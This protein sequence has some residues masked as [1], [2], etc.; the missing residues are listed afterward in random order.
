[1]AQQVFAPPIQRALR[2]EVYDAIRR[3]VVTNV[4][5]PGER[6]NEAEIARQ[7]QI[8]RAPIREALRQLEQEGLLV[9]RPRRGTFVVSLSRTDV[10]EV[11]TL[12]ADLECRAIRRAMEHLTPALCRTLEALIEEME[13][14]GRAS[15]VTR[16][17]EAD[18]AF[19]RAIVDAAGWHRLRRIWEG[20]HPQTLTTYTLTTLTD[21]P[22]SCHADRHRPIVQALLGGDSSAAARAIQDH[23]LEVSEQVRRRLPE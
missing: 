14:A 5:K 22:L 4:L 11:Y 6:V 9:S 19:H 20:L 18:I 16:L 1:M 12:R 3:A 7:M 10:E 8:S 13:A 2:S 15:D 23:I 17:L 21:W